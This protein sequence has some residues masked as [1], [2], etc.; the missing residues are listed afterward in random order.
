MTERE[1]AIIVLLLPMIILT[2]WAIRIMIGSDH[3]DQIERSIHVPVTIENEKRKKD[4][5]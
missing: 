2:S 4:R 3:E 1:V 5:Q